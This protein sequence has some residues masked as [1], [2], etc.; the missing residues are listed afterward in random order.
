MA[1]ENIRY[2][3][4]ILN[5]EVIT[6]DTGKRLGV[7]KELLVDVDRRQVV[8]LGLRD[9]R[10]AIAG[11]S[12]Y[13]YLESISQMGDVI[14]VE[15][16]DVIED[17]DIEVYSPLV[18]SEVITE[19]GELLGK[20]RS[21]KFDSEDGRVS[22]IIIDSLGVPFV[23]EQMM[24]TFELSIEEVVSSGPNRLIVFEGS[25]ERLNQI[26]VGLLEKIGLAKA[27][28]ERDDDQTY[29]PPVV[30]PENQLGTGLPVKA[31]A[32]APLRTAPPVTQNTWDEDDWEEEEIQP[33]QRKKQEVMYYEDEEEEDNWSEANNN[34]P[35]QQVKFEA[36]RPPEYDDYDDEE[37]AWGDV[38]T[39]EYK[40]QK[41][42]IP[43]KAKIVEY[44]E[45]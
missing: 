36:K 17:I 41:L 22:S 21:F 32:V 3:S 24:S 39:P 14:L 11:M 40:P 37:D 12:R 25:E 31:T 1:T 19:T 33:I 6:R 38:E 45:N 13:M 44:E 2:R 29:F 30:R 20:V 43:E 18:G 26:T 35:V 7:V 34:K 9:N 8:A 10:L 15:N 28:W 16:D 4:D 42:N 5:T 23:P 27:P